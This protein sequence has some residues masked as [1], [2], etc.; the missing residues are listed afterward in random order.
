MQL[1]LEKI[2]ERNQADG[3]LLTECDRRDAQ[4]NDEERIDKLASVLAGA[5]IR[6][7]VP[8]RLS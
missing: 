5:G 1:I 2:L 6:D 3:V 7:D 4:K 8:A